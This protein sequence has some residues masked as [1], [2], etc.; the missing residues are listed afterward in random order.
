MSGSPTHQSWRGMRERC[1]N[2]KNNHFKDYGGRGITLAKEWDS[3]EVFLTDMGERPEGKTLERNDVNLGYS[4]SN[5]CWADSMQQARNTRRTIHITWN[6]K[7]QCLKDWASDLGITKDALAYRIKRFGID[8][9]MVMRKHEWPD[10]SRNTRAPANE[11]LIKEQT[12]QREY[13]CQ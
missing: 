6:G 7:T 10:R 4:K 9:A 5:C 8:V 13:T 2:P 3:F 11:P 1:L 12:L